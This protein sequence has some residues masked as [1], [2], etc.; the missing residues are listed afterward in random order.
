MAKRLLIMLLLAL[1]LVSGCSSKEEEG[2]VVSGTVE[3]QEINVSSQISGQVISVKVEEGQDISKGD[4]L[5]EIDDQALALKY[6]QAEAALAS[7]KAQ[8]QDLKSGSRQQQLSQAAANVTKA[9]ASVTGAEKALNNARDEME[10]IK[11]LY[12][13]GAVSEQVYQQKQLMLEQAESSYSS[14]R[15]SLDGVGAQYSLIQEGATKETLNAMESQ[16]NQATAALQAAQLEWDKASVKAPKDGL[17]L[18]LNVKE[19]ELARPGAPA[20]TLAQLDTLHIETYIPE[21]WL[22]KVSY[23]QAVSIAVDGYDKR[24]DGSL[25]YIATEAEFT[26]QNLQTKETRV[27]TVYAARVKVTQE[28]QILKPGMP[29]DVYFETIPKDDGSAI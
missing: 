6:Q 29:V 19:G 20:I 10:R 26:P 2:L 1:F 11:A 27:D 9:A 15:S 3:A 28:G 13:K 25:N 17:V 21:P 14:A 22:A 7:L 18:T 5:F 4:I 8:Y 12:E 23:G 16:V 24:L